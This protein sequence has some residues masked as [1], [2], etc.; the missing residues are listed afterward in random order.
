MMAS[1]LMMTTKD[2]TLPLYRL[3]EAASGIA[4]KTVIDVTALSQNGYGSVI[5]FL[6][7]RWSTSTRS[8]WDPKPTLANRTLAPGPKAPYHVV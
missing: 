6:C 4:I 8:A 7:P 5:G 2:S 1:F 3:R